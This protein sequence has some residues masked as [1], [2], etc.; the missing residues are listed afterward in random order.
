MGKEYSMH[1]KRNARRGLVGNLDGKGLRP[2]RS[3]GDN[4]ETDL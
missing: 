1:G 3:W 4:I 2:R